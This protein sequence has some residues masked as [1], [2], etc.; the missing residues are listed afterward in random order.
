MKKWN[1]FNQAARQQMASSRPKAW[2]PSA[3]TRQIRCERDFF[4]FLSKSGT[5]LHT[6][7]PCRQTRAGL[8]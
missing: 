6:D 7:T 5:F 4:L 8:S 1:G 2:T 3:D